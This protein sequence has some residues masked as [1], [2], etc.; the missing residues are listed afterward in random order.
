VSQKEQ[1]RRLAERREDP[2]VFRF[3]EARLDDGSI[4]P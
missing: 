2:L 3:S 1:A 4:A